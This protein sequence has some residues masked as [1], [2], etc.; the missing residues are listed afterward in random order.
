[1]NLPTAIWCQTVCPDCAPLYPPSLLKASADDFDYA[2]RLRTGEIIKF[3]Y[4][5]IHGD[6]V[7]LYS[8][9]RSQITSDGLEP[10]E[11]HEQPLP[12]PF[13]R[14]IDVRLNDIVWCADAPNGS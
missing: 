9:S 13:L 12:F 4:A 2:L 5:E 11:G 6:Y 1:M 14:G 3:T 7:S 8:T 10:M